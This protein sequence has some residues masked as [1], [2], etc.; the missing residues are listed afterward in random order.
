MQIILSLLKINQILEY[1][2]EQ[3]HMVYIKRKRWWRMV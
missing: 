1:K 2:N 3:V